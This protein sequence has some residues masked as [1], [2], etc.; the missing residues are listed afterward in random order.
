MAEVETVSNNQK[1][2]DNLIKSGRVSQNEIGDFNTFNLLLSDSVN[3]SKLYGNLTKNNL[4]KPEE[5]G[6]RDDFF[7]NI[8]PIKKQSEPTPGQYSKWQNEFDAKQAVQQPISKLP[9]EQEQWIKDNPK[10]NA[11]LSTPGMSPIRGAYVGTKKFIGGI[12]TAVED[13]ISNVGDNITGG[14]QVNE[15]GELV[16]PWEKDY[17]QPEK[18][19]AYKE[20]RKWE[21]K[22]PV[23]TG[24]AGEFV[25]QLLPQ[26]TALATTVMLKN[27]AVGQAYLASMYGSSYGNGLEGY[28][29]YVKE[30][31][32]Q[33]NETDRTLV[34]VGYG[35]AEYIGEKI[36][37]DY[38]MPKGYGKLIAK[39][40]DANPVAAGEIG[41]SVLENYAKVTNQPLSAILKRF[42]IGSQVEGGE[43]VVTEL[44][45]VAID[46]WV[47]GRDVSGQE[48]KDRL[49]QSY[50]GGALMGASITPFS[51]IS[52][53]ASNT[54]RRQ[55]Q[56]KVAIGFDK[57]GLPLE[58]IQNE[59]GIFG[60]R[61]DGSQVDD[62]S[63]ETLSKVSTFRTEDFEA[64][65]KEM[66]QKGAELSKEWER[67]VT[68]KTIESN[69]NPLIN[70]ET[71]NLHVVKMRGKE[72]DTDPNYF[73]TQTTTGGMVNIVDQNGNNPFGKPVSID[74]LTTE[75]IFSPQ[76]AVAGDMQDWEATKQAEE[77]QA[78]LAEVQQ[79]K[80]AKIPQQF[81]WDGSRYSFDANDPE[82]VL[83]DEE[84]NTFYKMLELDDNGKDFGVIKSFS[85]DE[86]NKVIADNTKEDEKLQAEQ[87]KEAEKLAKEQ[88][89]IT[90]IPSG[91]NN[92]SE[93]K[94]ITQNFGN[95]PID[96]IEEDGYDEIVP[97]E[98]MP[99][100]KIL[101]ILEKKFKDH[102]KFKVE[103]DKSEVTTITPAKSKY[104][105]DIVTKKTVI[106][107]IKIVPKNQPEAPNISEPITPT[108][109]NTAVTPNSNA[110]EVAPEETPIEQPVNDI[111]PSFLFNAQESTPEANNEG[112]ASVEAK[113]VDIER[114]RQEELNQQTDAE[115]AALQPSL[116]NQSA[117]I[118][119]PIENNV[120]S[121]FKPAKYS[122]G[123]IA[124]TP[125]KSDNGWKTREARLATTKGVNGKFSNREGAYIMSESQSEKLKKYIDEGYDSNPMTNELIAPEV[126][127]KEN[128]SQPI[129]ENV[130][131]LASET[132][133]NTEGG[134]ESGVTNLQESNTN[135]EKSLPK[136]EGILDQIANIVKKPKPEVKAETP[137]ESE[138]ILDDIA[139]I[140]NRFPNV[141]S[142]TEFINKEINDHIKGKGLDKTEFEESEDYPSVFNRISDS[143]PSYIKDLADSGKLQTIFDNS[144]LGE[145]I[146]IRKAIETANF[147]VSDVLD[148][149]KV[150][151]EAK[152]KNKAKRKE[153]NKWM[154]EMGVSEPEAPYDKE[155][156]N[157]AYGNEENRQRAFE[158]TVQNVEERSLVRDN[159][160][161][162]NDLRGREEANGGENIAPQATG[163]TSAIPKV[164]VRTVFEGFKERGYSD[165][166][167]QTITGPQDIADLWAINRSANIEIS[168][169]VLLKGK[170]IIGSTAIT[171]NCS[172]QTIFPHPS[173]IYDLYNNYGAD[174]MYYIHNHP[175][176]NHKVSL[177]DIEVTAD[178]HNQL[179]ANGVNLIGHVV[180]DHDK[181]SYINISKKPLPYIHKS[182]LENYLAEDVEEF[183][184]KNAVP[185]LFSERE[186]L[187]E[188]GSQERMFEISKAL[189]SENGYNGAT[190]FLTPNMSIAA[191]NA[192]P[193]G[194]TVESLSKQAIE[195]IKN[196]LGSQVVFI[197]DGSMVDWNNVPNETLD[198]INTKLNQS[199]EFTKDGN[200][201]IFRNVDILWEPQ[202]PYGKPNIDKNKQ[203]IAPEKEINRVFDIVSDLNLSPLSIPEYKVSDEFRLER[204]EFKNKMINKY[205]EIGWGANL[206]SEEKKE[207]L[208]IE[209]KEGDK[210][211]SFY[212]KHPNPISDIGGL[213]W[214]VKKGF[215][216]EK[217]KACA[218]YIYHKLS[219]VINQG[220]TGLGNIRGQSIDEADLRDTMVNSKG[221]IIFDITFPEKTKFNLLNREKDVFGEINEEILP[222][223]SYWKY[224]PK[225]EDFE[226]FTEEFRSEFDIKGNTD[227]KDVIDPSNELIRTKIEQFDISKVKG[228]RQMF[229]DNIGKEL[230]HERT[231]ESDNDL[232]VYYTANELLDY[233]RRYKKSNDD[234]SNELFRQQLLNEPKSE[235]GKPN[236]SDFDSPLDFAEAVSRY[237]KENKP[238]NQ[239]EKI[240]L[241]RNTEF[242]ETG[243]TRVDDNYEPDDAEYNQR[244]V[245][246]PIFVNQWDYYPN[247][248]PDSETF[249]SV[250]KATEDLLAPGDYS[251]VQKGYTP[252]KTTSLILKEAWIDSDN[253]IVDEGKNIGYEDFA[254]ENK[255]NP[256]VKQFG[257]DQIIDSKSF[258]DREKTANILE[259]DVYS[260]IHKDLDK[261]YNGLN[262]NIPSRG[263][264]RTI[265][266]ENTKGDEVG[267]I[268]LR[269]ADHSYNPSNNNDSARSGNFISVEIANKNETAKRF[270][271]KHGL[272]FN[273][274]NTYDEIVGAVNDRI[275][276]IIDS[277]DIK[278]SFPSTISVNGVERP[279]TNSKGQPIAE[280]E[281]K[282]RNFWNWFGNSKVVDEE[283]RPL[284]VY[285]GTSGNEITEFSKKKLGQNTVSSYGLESDIDSDWYLATSYLGFWF[286]TQEMKKEFSNVYDDNIDVYLKLSSPFYIE[287]NAEL[288]DTIKDDVYSSFPPDEGYNRVD[289]TVTLDKKLIKNLVKS[290]KND[291]WDGII[292]KSDSEFGGRSFIAFSPT[293]IKSATG[294]NGNFS[295]NNP[296]IV[297]EPIGEYGKR[298][299]PANYDSPIDFAKD[300]SDYTNTVNEP[301]VEYEKKSTSLDKRERQL[302]NRIENTKNKRETHNS[303][304]LIKNKIKDIKA[305]WVI[306]ERDTKGNIA[307]IQ[308]EIIKYARKNIPFELAGKAELAKIFSL[309]KF[310]NTPERLEN[311]F[312]QIDDI[313][314]GIDKEN[315][316][317]KIDQL[318]KNNKQKKVNKQDRGSL[319]PEVY[320]VLQKI[321]NIRKVASNRIVNMALAAEHEN[322]KEMTH[323][324]RVGIRN[325]IRD[326]LINDYLGTIDEEDIESIALYSTFGNLENK[327]REDVK[328]AMDK[329]ASMIATG[330]AWYN[331]ALNARKKYQQEIRNKTLDKITGEQGLTSEQ[332]LISSGKQVKTGMLGK[333]I[334]AHL[335]F[336][337]LLDKLSKD[338]TEN[339]GRGFMQDYFGDLVTKSTNAE[340]KGIREQITK[341]HDK[342][343]EI[344]GLDG[345][346]LANRFRKNSKVKISSG[347]TYVNEKGNRTELPMSQNQAFQKWMEWENPKLQTT[348]EKMGW[349]ETTRKELESFM[350]SDVKKYS[351]YLIDE[352]YNKYH[353]G[354]N[355]KHKEAYFAPHEKIERYVPISREVTEVTTV[356]DG[357]LKR[358]S[359]IATVGNRSL[360]SRVSNTHHLLLKDGMTVLMQHISEMEHFKAWVMEMNELRSVFSSRQVQQAIKTYHGESVR[361]NLN[362]Q[363]ADMASG[364]EDRANIID[365]ADFVRRNFSTAELAANL[366]MFPK[367]AFS[368]LTFISE[369]PLK[370][371]VSGLGD[372]VLHLRK[373]VNTLRSNEMVT[374]RYQKGWA[375][376]IRA[377]LKQGESATLSQSKSVLGDIRNFLMFPAKAGDFV[378]MVAGWTVY[379]YEH[380]KQIASGKSEEEAHEYAL[381]KFDRSASRTL[382]S[383]ALK[384]I[385]QI[386]KGSWNKIFTMFKSSPIQQFRYENAAFRNMING[387]GSKANN[388]KIIAVYHLVLPMMFQLISNLFT[389]DDDDVEI[390]RLIRAGILG[391]ANS[392]MIVGDIVEAVLER[393]MGETWD[394]AATPLEG[395]ISK[396]LQGVGNLSSGIKD[397]DKEKVLKGLDQLIYSVNNISIGLPYRPGKKIIRQVDDI[398]H[399]EQVRFRDAEKEFSKIT[400][401]D[402]E[403]TAAKNKYKKEENWTEF[404]K[405]NTDLKRNRMHFLLYGE[406]TGDDQIY[407]FQDYLKG[408]KKLFDNKKI[409][410]EQYMIKASEIMEK[411]IGKINNSK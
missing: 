401:D 270:N 399:P 28:D 181:F 39:T 303:H 231:F 239:E 265:S 87:I 261:K 404:K 351:E 167:G 223:S 234:L 101:P 340:S 249:S 74:D 63:P 186:I 83:T 256:F 327:S 68:Q 364:G 24:G 86:V 329:L 262:I 111:S 40:F 334:N 356:E 194:A 51:M 337:W 164:K 52:Q 140:A 272:Q 90:T 363:I 365:F 313:I 157:I 410:E 119:T 342:A 304:T 150:H 357:M 371:Y 20:I 203:E 183:E 30:K 67:T 7:L 13:L 359:L 308:N 80:L 26:T 269:I 137:K 29:D 214:G 54:T 175:S 284:V 184:Y 336:E 245:F 204:D 226:K 368:I 228:I 206:N 302:E 349:D 47:T 300:L 314:Y 248:D 127:Q 225:K 105:D 369:V 73:I 11:V 82:S 156:I 99:L 15:N 21:N 85:Q 17:K 395:S 376:E 69:L 36:G 110:A 341:V 222:S 22:G 354:I 299:D 319:D 177:K 280:T 176:G 106:K 400:K 209:K 107:G 115:L 77:Q 19:D 296:S 103:V 252:T 27:P 212:E 97:S 322:F 266:V 93:R 388:A 390:K 8:N 238:L 78:R 352:F 267:S 208:E 407:G 405:L 216:T 260:D 406:G 108:E 56:G 409:S 343:V 135:E 148:L 178:Q 251:E 98:K 66:K 163:K 9:P 100:E 169:I 372:M 236:P 25:G 282:V 306:G 33:P 153:K 360:R 279:T 200:S 259:S 384:D 92:L 346:K 123:N 1:L 133:V 396:G 374:E 149:T 192:F 144:R 121:S 16:S 160:G 48:I 271:G 154:D 79:Q 125:P 72:E 168:G 213:T 379:K 18:S 61:P 6:T 292:V 46:K 309:V 198:I 147:N 241:L 162:R 307:D 129:S 31:G 318:L 23:L 264:Y 358:P 291:D 64:G 408:Q 325:E 188:Y 247:T 240:D 84:G 49:I 76:Q 286:N 250:D 294:N 91:D 34:G 285:H 237:A 182:S 138:G 397:L 71:G 317:K 130:S 172:D 146:K 217:E 4:F 59:Q 113:K 391:S 190:V 232:D 5:I 227:I 128:I 41:K 335:N 246:I 323:E 195:G 122:K 338:K 141:L 116:V 290:Y 353:E 333:F 328:E 382:Q 375:P 389:D 411:A 136:E 392:L 350:L 387:R 166:L 94:I 403:W 180:I 230:D 58:I 37:L 355:K 104:D 301:K 311:S 191:Y 398:V 45:D 394:Y 273:G 197:H 55:E 155:E 385:S 2:Y 255:N 367:Q 60:I 132:P 3:A 70:P 88:Q 321:R 143:Y 316:I 402:R 114:R 220:S 170:K 347:V 81:E 289:R 277:W 126:S 381:N 224:T 288:V 310:S 287:D 243:E 386:Q 312:N 120:D 393:L 295:E 207:E 32:I 324:E 297:E 276:E 370:N 348:F 253:N 332:D 57:E 12:G 159:S 134:T 305:G 185:R 326:G 38:F 189:L 202:A 244:R 124:Y 158:S 242:I 118:G 95:T 215:I 173:Q 42:A 151:D 205:G 281:E 320:P 117:E 378:S 112:G 331:E 109:E 196:N 274:E 330:K 142:E 233:Y 283:G 193:D 165:I 14:V 339:T 380:D 131:H 35:A 345:K 278:P 65:M 102:P 275:K 263:K 383:G 221:D 235:Y 219:K 201:K 229:N 145:Q 139:A 187:P 377:T 152:A 315:D 75:Q 293:Q 257:L 53:N 362:Q 344:Y 43:E 373:A 218:K 171:C 258:D 44:M 361:A 89:N 50:G 62:I 10:L 161:G 366:S 211:K 210:R 96:I 298:P 268:Q 254:Y 174:G 199:D 179:K